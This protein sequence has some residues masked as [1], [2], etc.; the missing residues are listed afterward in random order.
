MQ[1]MQAP[2]VASVAAAAAA[3]GRDY[4]FA[5]M[6]HFN[7]DVPPQCSPQGFAELL[8]KRFATAQEAL[9]TAK[10]LAAAAGFVAQIRSKHG[11]HDFDIYCSRAGTPPPKLSDT[12]PGVKARKAKACVKCD[13]KWRL[14]VVVEAAAVENTQHANSGPEWRIALPVN[15]PPASFSEGHNHDLVVS[16]ELERPDNVGRIITKAE[17]TEDIMTNVKLLCRAPNMRQHA[18]PGCS[19]SVLRQR[20]HGSPRACCPQSAQQHSS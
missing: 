17:L 15:N 20:R 9:S 18:A 14:R 7:C 1:V 5:V 12:V 16:A 3:A 13:C 4:A 6:S 8:G 11:G 19:Q 10:P 2:A